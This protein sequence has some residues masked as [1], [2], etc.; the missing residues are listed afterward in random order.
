[1]RRRSVPG[2]RYRPGHHRSRLARGPRYLREI[3]RVIGHGPSGPNV[4]I[5][6]MPS[7][8]WTASVYR[9]INWVPPLSAVDNDHRST[10]T[11]DKF[12]ENSSRAGH[13]GP[14]DGTSWD[15]INDDYD[16]L[17]QQL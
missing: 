10:E 12:H 1:R 7:K 15:V 3:S 17:R 14:H 9:G 13:P 4:V 16:P 11:L 8:P 6:P 5:T 2:R